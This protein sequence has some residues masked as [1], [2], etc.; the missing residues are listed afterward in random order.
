[1][2]RIVF[3]RPFLAICA[4]NSTCHLRPNSAS[5]PTDV[6]S[7]KKPTIVQL[8]AAFRRPFYFKRVIKYF[9]SLDATELLIPFKT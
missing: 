2:V 7:H 3:R 9:N 6:N 8:I 1:M 4:S 5:A